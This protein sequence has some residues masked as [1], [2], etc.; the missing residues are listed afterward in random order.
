[1]TLSGSVIAFGKL[2][3]TIGGK[4]LTLPAR[5]WLNLSLLVI[6]IWFGRAF[7]I[8]SAAGGGPHAAHRHDRRR[9]ALRRAHGDGDRR[10]GHAGRR[11]DAEQLLGL[12]RVG[13][14][15][16]AEQRPADRHGRAGRQQRR[17][18]ELHHVPRDEP[19]VPVGHRRRVRHGR[20]RQRRRPAPRRRRARRV[21]VDAAEAA[22]LLAAGQGRRHRARLRHGRRA[23]AARRVRDHE[24]AARA[25][26]QACA[27][28]FIRSPAACP[29]T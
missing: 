15:L 18:P 5:H 20:W 12:G 19:E 2:S 26:R 23:G 3:G 4:P 10:R 8:E 1:M 14:R 11:V 22:A 24:A 9:A 27:S 29:A 16:H 28:R 25:R 17:D 13:D 6:A 21:P 7:V